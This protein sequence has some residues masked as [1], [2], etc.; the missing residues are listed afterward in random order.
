MSVQRGSFI[1][2]RCLRVSLSGLPAGLRT[3]RA[4]TPVAC[5]PHYG[6]VVPC[7]ELGASGWGKPRPFRPVLSSRRGETQHLTLSRAYL[8]LLEK[9]LGQFVPVGGGCRKQNT[10]ACH[11]LTGYDAGDSYIPNESCNTTAAEYTKSAVVPFRARYNSIR[12]CGRAH[13]VACC[14]SE[15]AWYPAVS[16]AESVTTLLCSEARRQ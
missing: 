7:C 11:T 1:V 3:T 16:T 13:R 5:H 15:N 8:R 2:A 4:A 10:R 14:T 6:R 9:Q 12:N